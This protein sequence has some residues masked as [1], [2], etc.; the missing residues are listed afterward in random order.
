[1]ATYLMVATMEH[2]AMTTATLARRERLLDRL[3]RCELCGRYTLRI[4][5]RSKRVRAAQRWKC[6]NERYDTWVCGECE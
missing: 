5:A 1:M 3:V 6:V 4:V 2:P